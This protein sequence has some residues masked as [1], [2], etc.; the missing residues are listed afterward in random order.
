[1]KIEAEN[2][3]FRYQNKRLSLFLLFC[4]VGTIFPPVILV[5]YA[6]SKT[7]SNPIIA[8]CISIFITAIAVL[9][10][11]IQLIKSELQNGK[12]I[13]TKL[14]LSNNKIIAT[15]TK[16]VLFK[17]GL[18]SRDEV[19]HKNINDYLNFRKVTTNNHDFNYEFFDSNFNHVYYKLLVEH[20]SSPKQLKK[21]IEEFWKE[22]EDI[23]V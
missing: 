16:L 23:M 4:I 2:S 9:P 15:T 20:Y 21:L 14:S 17:N 19:E 8:G 18:V 13:I 1:M 10:G 7:D 11:A 3:I 12:K 5:L 22:N 6:Q